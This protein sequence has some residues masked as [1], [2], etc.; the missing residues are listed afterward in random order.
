MPTR[1]GVLVACNDSMVCKPLTKFRTVMLPLL[2]LGASVPG[3]LK[4]LREVALVN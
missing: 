4:R 3:W 2:A 1:V